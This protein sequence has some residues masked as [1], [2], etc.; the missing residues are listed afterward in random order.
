MTISADP[1]YRTV[2]LA[3][4][5]NGA[6]GDEVVQVFA[7]ASGSIW[8]LV[9]SFAVAG[10]NQVSSWDSALPLTAYDVAMRYVN[11]SVPA[12]GYEGEPDDWTA[13]TAPQSKSTVTTTSAGVSWV[14]GVFVDASTPITLSWSSSQQGVPYLLEKNAG[15]GWVTVASDLVATSYVYTVDPA[16][17]GLTVDFRVTAQR[18]LV[19]G[20]SA[21]VRSVPMYIALG[22]PVLAGTLDPTTNIVHLTWSAASGAA[23]YILEKNVNGAGWVTVSGVNPTAYDYTPLSS[24]IGIPVAFRVSANS[25]SSTGSPSN[26]VTLTPALLP[27]TFAQAR[28]DRTPVFIGGGPPWHVYAAWVLNTVAGATSYEVQTSID[29]G[30][31]WLPVTPIAGQS[32]SYEVGIDFV[33]TINIRARSLLGTTPSAWSPSTSVVVP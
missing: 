2:S 8:S 12:V 18:G 19:V 32:G 27:P 10:G 26:V 15:S 30:T 3:F 33:G 17:L 22:T 28:Y 31:T 6:L 29:G 1:R 13:I 23:F 11:G 20:P 4:V 25:G 5:N 24:E 16:E 7:K 14:G 21:G 9:R